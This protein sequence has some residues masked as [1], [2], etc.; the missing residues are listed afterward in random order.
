[1]RAQPVEKGVDRLGIGAYAHLGGRLVQVAAEP[2]HHV[3]FHSREALVAVD[4]L[5]PAGDAELVVDVEVHGVPLRFEKIEDLAGQLQGQRIVMQQA[6]RADLAD[7]GALVRGYRAVEAQVSGIA[8]GGAEHPSRHQDGGDADL[9]ENAHGRDGERGERLRAVEEQRQE[10]AVEVG[11]DDSGR[12]GMGFKVRG[13]HG[14][15]LP[16]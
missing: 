9:I 3:R 13:R 14:D 5:G 11:S 2:S 4:L 15:R 1:M 7:K 6:T 16:G 10:R 12:V 8:R